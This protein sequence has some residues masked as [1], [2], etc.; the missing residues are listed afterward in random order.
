MTVYFSRV[1]TIVC[2]VWRCMEFGAKGVV[3]YRI[4]LPTLNCEVRSVAC[5]TFFE[6]TMTEWISVSYTSHSHK[7]FF[8][9]CS[10][11]CC[12]LL[13]DTEHA[14]IAYLSLPS[15]SLAYLS[16]AFLSV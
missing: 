13:L 3:I 5:G 12:P 4:A 7:R 16:L 8:V 2:G 1:P 15:L 6:V 10:A 9:F 11:S 14:L